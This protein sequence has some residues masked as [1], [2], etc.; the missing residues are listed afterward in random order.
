MVTPSRWRA[1]RIWGTAAVLAAALSPPAQA[2]PIDFSDK[3]ENALLCR[4][5]WSTAYWQAYFDKALQK[6]LRDW[7]EAR[8]WSA[9]GAQLGGVSATELFINIGDGRALMI[10]ALI[11]QPIEQARPA[12]EARLR[13][14]F[15]PIQAA[16]GTRYINDTL[17]VLAPTSDGQ[18]K[19]YCARWNLGN[20]P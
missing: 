4:S 17:S 20:R 19:W 1:G 10:G 8:W 5:E 15:K 14:S 18:T 3:V 2:L 12:I 11:S 9:Q 7:G 6:P 13:T 16:D